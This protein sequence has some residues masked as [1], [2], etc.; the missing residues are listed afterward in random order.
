MKNVFRETKTQAFALCAITLMALFAFALTA[1]DNGTNPNPNPNV[2]QDLEGW[3]SITN[4]AGEVIYLCKAG[5]TIKADT[6]ELEAEGTFSY[7]WQFSDDEFGQDK[8]FTDIT[9]VTGDSYIVEDT[10]KGKFIRVLVTCTGYNGNAVSNTVKVRMADPEITSVTIGGKGADDK[11]TMSKG[12][13]ISL[14][15]TVAGQNLES[16]DLDV[17]WSMTGNTNP[18]TAIT[19][20][21]NLTVAIDE[22][23]DELQVTAASKIDATKEDTVTVTLTEFRGSII[24]ITGLTGQ[25]GSVQVKIKETLAPDNWV[26]VAYGDGEINNET[27]MV[28]LSYFLETPWEGRGEYF[29]Q[30]AGLNF[31]LDTYIYT[32]GAALITT[33]LDD[34][35]KYDFQE[36]KTTIDFSKF[37]LLQYGQGGHTV[38]VTG[39]GAFNGAVV[40]VEILQLMTDT[41]DDETVYYGETIASGHAVISNGASMISLAQVVELQEQFAGWTA[42]N[43]EY[44]IKM[45]ITSADTTGAG[46]YDVREHV[47]TNGKTLTELG[48]EYWTDF[49][50]KAPKHT[51]TGASSS[52]AFDKFK[53]SDEIGYSGF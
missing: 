50:I 31:G 20:W 41:W 45:S 43:G 12:T 30:L 32:N 8:D 21:G 6:S 22:T 42:D 40:K 24:T 28:P 2:T 48:I 5:E 49:W 14:N 47:Y 51:F 4:A 17:I 29:I 36:S 35:P 52:I 15:A 18:G 26:N 10:L 33:D 39:L 53:K 3:V 23:A 34:N 37:K 44:F 9:S 7:K 46:F 1:C 38:T 19:D 11:I 16:A 13:G 25:S 27:L